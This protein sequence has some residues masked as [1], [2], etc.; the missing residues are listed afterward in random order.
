MLHAY[1]KRGAVK[2]V[3]TLHIDTASHAMLRVEKKRCF[4]PNDWHDFCHAAASLAYCDLF[5]TEGPLHELVARPKLGLLGLNGC[6]IAS[7]VNDTVELLRA[8]STEPGP[9]Q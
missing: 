3:R 6:K 4:K 9:I 2:T 1:R 5:F 8:V 7:T